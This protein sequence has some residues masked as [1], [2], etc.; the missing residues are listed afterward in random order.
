MI[1]KNVL[2]LTQPDTPCALVFDSPHS[3]TL[4]PDDFNYAAQCPTTILEKCED[5]YIDDLFSA[6][7]AFH[8]PLLC[9][10]FPRSYIDANRNIKDI[11]P[12]LITGQWQQSPL[13]QQIEPSN[14]S[15]A[16]IGLVRRLLTPTQR[17]Y[18]RN[19]TQDEIEHRIQTYYRPYHQT[20]ERLIDQAHK[21]FG[22]V[23]HI[24]CHSMP[25]HSAKSNR[26]AQ[27]NAF[28][29][30]DFVLG[31]RDG[32]SCHKDFTHAIRDHLAQN[33]Y[34]VAIN[35]PYKGVELV[36]RYSNPAIGRHSLQIEINRALYLD[37]DTYKKSK[38]YEK[39][40]AD[41][42]SLIRFCADY[43]SAQLTPMAAD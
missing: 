23:W 15:L 30:P 9:A 34:N 4:Y 20:L 19:L 36:R 29:T 11:D 32:T 18:D 25:S 7:P 28:K 1:I 40:K 41:I 37:E 12:E 17:L 22:Q 31:D 38:N 6:A 35:D 14:L 42:T 13:I 27:I 33:G 10:L 5:K 21:H 43:T 24:N 39:L 3:G 26:Q 8:A 2:K 16:G